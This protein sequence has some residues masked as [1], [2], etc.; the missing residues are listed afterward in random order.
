MVSEPKFHVKVVSVDIV[1]YSLRMPLLQSAIVK[2][3]TRHLKEATESIKTNTKYTSEQDI[4]FLPSGDGILTLFFDTDRTPGIHIQF[5]SNLLKIIANQNNE[6]TCLKIFCSHDDTS[7]CECEKYNIRIGIDQGLAVK[8]TDINNVN[9]YAG[10]P[11]NEACRLMG[12]A[13]INQIA[14]SPCVYAEIG[15]FLEKEQQK[16]VKEDTGVDKHGKI[17]T[18]HV[19]ADPPTSQPDMQIDNN[20]IISS[21]NSLF[22]EYNRL[23]ASLSEP[24]RLV[25][26]K[27]TLTEYITEIEDLRT[28]IKQ[29]GRDNDPHALLQ[30][31][32]TDF[33]PPLLEYCAVDFATVQVLRNKAK[34]TVTKPIVISASAVVCCSEQR[35]IILHHRSEKSS[36]YPNCLHTL[37]G[38]YKPKITERS[39]FALYDPNLAVTAIREILEESGLSIQWRKSIPLWWLHE[40]KT[41]FVQLLLAG[42]S[43]TTDNVGIMESSWEGRLKLI[44]FDKLE[45]A[46]LASDGLKWTPTGLMSILLWLA[47][48]AH[49]A[50]ANPDFNGKK[51]IPLFHFLLQ[52]IIDRGIDNL[53]GEAFPKK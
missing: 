50:G 31:F 48:G 9:N 35:Q 33:T 38:S 39:N 24:P 43:V 23:E 5:A 8:F 6:T 1:K 15:G 16:R 27:S 41:G 11:L 22:K 47:N 32:S 14:L 46:V 34:D 42:A 49:G 21:L 17:K 53:L 29:A 13:P 52:Q 18:F 7:C 26:K 51:P 4:V 20:Q 45:E 12:L 2:L 37:G 3:F 28:E 44:A 40:T 10:T 25:E 19:L 36:T 30:Y